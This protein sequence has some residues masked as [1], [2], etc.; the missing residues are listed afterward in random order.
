LLQI[1][2]GLCA[3][4]RI[5]DLQS[6]GP[7][8]HEI[9]RILWCIIS[10]TCPSLIEHDKIF[11]GLAFELFNHFT[12]HKVKH[13]LNILTIRMFH[14]FLLSVLAE[15]VRVRILGFVSLLWFRLLIECLESALKWGI[16]SL[17]WAWVSIT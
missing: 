16:Y 3:G 6:S 7:C 11:F 15:K 5:V 14:L 1:C 9:C 10:H 13:E 12:V 8:F 2:I 17:P 4:E